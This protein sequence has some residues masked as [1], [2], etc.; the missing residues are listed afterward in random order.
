MKNDFE[1]IGVKIRILPESNY[2]AIFY[3]NCTF[4]IAL[5]SN[6]PITELEYPEFLDIKLTNKCLGNCPYCYQ[7][8]LPEEEHY[9]NIVDKL[10]NYFSSMSLNQRPFQIAYGGGEPTLHPEFLDVLKITKE[11]FDIVPNYT[12]NGM[13]TKDLL[14]NL[15]DTN[16]FND[17]IH[18]T[19]KYCGGVAIS[20]HEHLEKYWRYAASS[21][22][23][24]DIMLN[25][26]IIISSQKSIDRFVEI[27]KQWES[28]VSYFVL[29]PLTPTGRATETP[30]MW[31]YLMRNIVDL[32]TSKI[33]FGAM[34]H[35][36]LI[37]NKLPFSL[38]LY[39]PELMSKY[40]DLKDMKLYKSS[41]NL[42]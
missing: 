31:E 2:K 24:N 39:E 32:D 8:S 21:Y 9:T 15:N 16:Y 17:L 25:F 35:P 26:H 6:K 5:D 1:Q 40:L 12:T 28:Q 19:K 29:L 11:E 10:R 4:R 42:T 34:F 23:H 13:W 36:Y 41:F 33:A 7:N 37:G 3:K 27:Y 38:S 20:C 14:N 30:I 18:Y 22:Y